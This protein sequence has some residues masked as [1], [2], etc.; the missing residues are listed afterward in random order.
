[1]V[2]PPVPNAPVCIPINDP[3]S[4]R[5]HGR[6][7]WTGA[8]AIAVQQTGSS[9]ANVA[10][11]FGFESSGGIEFRQAFRR[12]TGGEPASLIVRW[13]NFATKLNK[14]SVPLN[15][16]QRIDGSRGVA[17]KQ[18]LSTLRTPVRLD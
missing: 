9:A 12:A 2:E 16:T 4:L 13:V 15:R 14:H 10:T 3:E 17:S 18:K 1:M 8:R 11:V 6:A 5:S 7:S